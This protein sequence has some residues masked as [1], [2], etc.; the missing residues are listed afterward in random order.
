MT[1]TGKDH[2]GA[3]GQSTGTARVEQLDR[4]VPLVMKNGHIQVVPALGQQQVGARGAVHLQALRAQLR[5]SGRGD[6]AV[7][8]AKQAVLTGV[9]VDA[10]KPNARLRQ[11]HAAHGA[12]TGQ[13]GLGDQLGAQ[14]VQG[15]LH[16]FVQR[17]V[18]DAQIAADQ[19]HENL[20]G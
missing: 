6:A 14:A 20:V 10:K 3:N 17:D 19:H 15:G 12:G 2:V 1:D 11:A 8:V 16:T 13:C 4:D 9:G 7:F 5:C 18:H